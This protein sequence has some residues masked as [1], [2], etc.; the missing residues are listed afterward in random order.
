M[1][2]FS[3]YVVTDRHSHSS[4]EQQ[5]SCFTA[6]VGK[7]RKE[8]DGAAVQYKL[9]MAQCRTEYNKILL[10]GNISCAHASASNVLKTVL[11]YQA[12]GKSNNDCLY[13]CCVV[14]TLIAG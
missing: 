10:Q 11:R 6:Y 9:D 3:G 5:F 7:K 4:F 8:G 1:K 12:A 13:T 2:S 14:V